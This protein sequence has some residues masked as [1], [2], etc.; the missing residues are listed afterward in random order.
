MNRSSGSSWATASEK[1]II[2][3]VSEDTLVHILQ[4]LRASD[5]ASAAETGRTIFSR[6]RIRRAALHQVI[7]I[8]NPYLILSNSPVMKQSSPCH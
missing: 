2:Y 7:H 3:K 6:S 4:Y 8:Y 1:P 5:L